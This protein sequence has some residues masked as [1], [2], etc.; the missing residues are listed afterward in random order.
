MEKR[1][2]YLGLESA[3]IG[4]A[5]RKL[6]KGTEDCNH[7]WGVVRLKFDPNTSA[8]EGN[9][10]C[11]VCDLLMAYD[12]HEWKDTSHGNQTSEGIG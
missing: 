3:L 5:I 11:I 9:A 2:R 7:I 6:P 4:D 10:R 12:G 8:V 1:N